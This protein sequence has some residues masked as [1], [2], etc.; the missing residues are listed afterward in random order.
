MSEMAEGTSA[1]P[2]PVKRGNIKSRVN[3]VQKNLDAINYW[4]KDNSF[5]LVRFFPHKHGIQ[6]DVH[7]NGIGL[8]FQEQIKAE[9]SK[10]LR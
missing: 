3:T 10:F 5:Y 2:P 8:D 7:A 1:L 6:T 9:I 4:H